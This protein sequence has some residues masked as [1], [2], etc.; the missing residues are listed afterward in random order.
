MDFNAALRATHGLFPRHT[1][2]D[3]ASL[4]Y[5]ANELH[6]VAVAI[7]H[8]ERSMRAAAQELDPQR[9]VDCQP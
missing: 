1:K 5:T 3:A 9:T 7:V 6:K 8:L 2:P 4:R